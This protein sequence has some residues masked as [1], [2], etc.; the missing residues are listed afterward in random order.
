[1]ELPRTAHTT[2]RSST[3]IS[4][5]SHSYPTDMHT[6]KAD[7]TYCAPFSC[8]YKDLDEFF[9]KDAL[10]YDI[11]LPGTTSGTQVT[12]LPLDKTSHPP[13]FTR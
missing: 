13:L 6:N 12:K 5:S 4:I 2:A 8:N 7:A 3:S 11:E 1:M 10:L 9:A